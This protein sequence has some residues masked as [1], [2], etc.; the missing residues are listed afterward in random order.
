VKIGFTCSSF[1]LLHAGH[2]LML[3]DAKS[4]CDYLIVGLQT[5]P[6]IDR[7]YK[8]K[9]FQSIVERQI[10]LSAVK[11]VDEIVVYETEADLREV[12]STRHIDVAILGSD[13]I[14]KNF[15]G[16]DFYES[17]SIE[18]YYHPRDHD[19]SSTN[20]VKKIQKRP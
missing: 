8:R 4:K 19:Y 11:Y 1:D 6:S 3:K 5:D 18:I 10:Q 7:N 16:K 9:P 14:G 2:V 12:L 17:N 20:L 13:Y 15:N